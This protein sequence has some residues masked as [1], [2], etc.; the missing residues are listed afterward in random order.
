[1]LIA[2]LPLIV[3]ILGLVLFI[4]GTP[5]PQRWVRVGELMFFAGLLVLLFGWSHLAV[6]LL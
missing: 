2:V 3:A 4:A 1:M 6:K 5:A